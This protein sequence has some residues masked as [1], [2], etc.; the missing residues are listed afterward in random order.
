MSFHNDRDHSKA[1][2][3]HPSDHGSGRYNSSYGD[4]RNRYQI[5]RSNSS[6]ASIPHDHASR[7]REP[8]VSYREPPLV[9]PEFDRNKLKFQRDLVLMATVPFNDNE[10]DR[11]H[12]LSILLKKSI[13]N[14]KKM[15]KSIEDLGN[16]LGEA[17]DY[18]AGCSESVS[19]TKDAESKRSNL[20]ARFQFYQSLDGSLVDNVENFFE[21]PN[22]F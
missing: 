2:W 5:N 21:R 8:P 22:T 1:P 11:D 16:V 17:D 14:Q 6:A 10:D 12:P 9:V 7:P 20:D 4:S 13:E 18:V 15:L 3:R 19:A